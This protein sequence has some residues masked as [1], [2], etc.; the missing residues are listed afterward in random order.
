VLDWLDDF[1]A[2]FDAAREL[3]PTDPALIPPKGNPYM[4]MSSDPDEPEVVP[5]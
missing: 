3:G 4:E 1:T 2:R 5:V